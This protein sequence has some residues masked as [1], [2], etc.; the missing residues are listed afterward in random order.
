MENIHQRKILKLI[1]FILVISIFQPFFDI[2]LL[3][4]Y[5]QA[6][7]YIDYFIIQQNFYIFILYIAVPL[8]ILYTLLKIISWNSLIQ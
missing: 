6:A 8:I 1:F 3:F 5:G 4:Q 7:S 2:F